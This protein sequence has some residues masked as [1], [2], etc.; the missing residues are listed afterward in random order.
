M[1][2]EP[3]NTRIRYT[4][5]IDWKNPLEPIWV[6]PCTSAEFRFTGSRLKIYVRNK[7]EY[8]QNYLG[9]ILDGVQSCHYLQNDK[10]TEIEISVPQNETGEHH[11]LFF[12][13]QDSCHEMTI[14]GY[15]IE[16]GATLLDLPKA[17]L[18]EMEVYGDS[19]SAGEVTEAVDFTGQPDPEHEGGYSNSWYSYAWLT[20][21]MLNAQI[22]D[23][24]QG[25]IALMDGQGWFHEPEQVG[26]ESAW[27]KIRF[28][29]TFGEL[30]EWDFSQ[31]TPQVVVVAIGQ[32]DNHPVDY[33]RED[34]SGKMAQKWKQHYQKLLENL[35]NV[36]PQTQIV[37]CTTLLQHDV[38]WDRAIG[39]VVEAMEDK[40]ITQCIFQRNGAATPG[41]LRIPENYEM[42]RELADYIQKL[43]IAEWK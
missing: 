18:R 41:H 12:K 8:W 11:V 42:A 5:R 2:I 25:G 21:R 22:H 16:D 26:M 37:C 35:R 40:K 17:P 39:Q 27:N 31:Y 24:A 1:R 38:S 33:M 20:A 23:I 36:Y 28:N 15:E 9:C 3:D 13:R 30:T 29:K 6:Y 7:N 34:P 10:D 19:V 32:N 4:G 43:D 14:L